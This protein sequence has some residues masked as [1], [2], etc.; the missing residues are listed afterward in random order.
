MP[1]LF[2]YDDIGPDWAG[3]V[4]AKRFI[5]DLAKIPADESVTV[6]INSQGGSV[7]EADA[8]YNAMLRRGVAV[9]IDGLA[10]SAA[11]LVAMA[12]TTI[13]IAANALVVIH[14]P[15]TIAMGD[16]REMR[17]VADILDKFGGSLNGVY[18][19]KTGQDAALIQEWMDAETWMN[20]EEAVERKFA[21]S[22]VD[23]SD[24]EAAISPG[25]FRNAPTTMPAA[26][27]QARQPSLWSRTVLKLRAEILRRSVQ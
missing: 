14:N 17:K 24:V 13:E 18:A 19:R 15:W 10:A 8:I 1:E 5:D 4:S 26:A 6:R 12:G 21:T 9:A 23:A 3:M 7:I 11:S 22:I 27:K 20:A 2:I 16:A 25:R